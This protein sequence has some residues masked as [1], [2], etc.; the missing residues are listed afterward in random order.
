V[1]GWLNWYSMLF[2]LQ[3]INKYILM[4][5]VINESQKQEKNML[6]KMSACILK[7][8]KQI[9]TLTLCHIH[10]CFLIVNALMWLLWL[11]ILV[12]KYG[13]CFAE[14]VCASVVHPSG[15][16]F[17]TWWGQNWYSKFFNSK[18]YFSPLPQIPI[19]WYEKP[20]V[21]FELSP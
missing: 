15:L 12:V 14:L 18:I 2:V 3:P 4:P 11:V 10:G 9:T 1:G 21:N 17:D 6:L 7:P 20:R 16:R 13:S 19:A 8:S 5:M